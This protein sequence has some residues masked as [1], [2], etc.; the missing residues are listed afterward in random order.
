MSLEL[1]KRGAEETPPHFTRRAA[2]TDD[3]VA[4]YLKD[5]DDPEFSDAN[6]IAIAAS[7]TWPEVY[8]MPARLRDRLTQLRNVFCHAFGAPS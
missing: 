2:L 4:R 5:L 6:R 7:W 3:E 1:Q 8:A